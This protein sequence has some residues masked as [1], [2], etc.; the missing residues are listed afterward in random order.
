MDELDALM[1]DA[2]AANK[3]V[4]AW[5][6]THSAQYAA[7]AEAIEALR[8]KL[9]P[10]NAM[11]ALAIEDPLAQLVAPSAA[12][13]ASAPPAAPAV[14]TPTAAPSA[15]GAASASPAA[16]GLIG[17]CALP[18]VFYYV[19]AHERTP[20]PCV[21]DGLATLAL[22]KPLIRERCVPGDWIV[23]ICG[24]YHPDA[25]TAWHGAVHYVAEVAECLTVKQYAERYPL[26]PD[27]VFD[28]TQGIR[29]GLTY[30]VSPQLCESL[31]VTDRVVIL[32]NY[33]NM[34]ASSV[35]VPPQLVQGK[36]IG[37]GY[38]REKGRDAVAALRSFLASTLA[39]VPAAA[40]V[41]VAVVVVAAPAVVVATVAAPA[42]AV[43]AAPAP[44]A[45]SSE[46]KVVMDPGFACGS[47][48]SGRAHG[49]I[50]QRGCGRGS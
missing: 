23:G 5:L 50:P 46:M 28:E 14:A 37:E 20:A 35:R 34:I 4:S 39:P 1:A 18:S 27:Q 19:C 32:A 44:L 40:P 29:T 7:N 13:A 9:I 11:N 36:H 8:A 43:V 47:A 12:A 25:D 6:A 22:C 2:A 17:A 26:R 48:G 42:A 30:V 31:L 15:A 24:K 21:A 33:V 10:P 41:V 45:I 16:P 3:K 49:G 38:V